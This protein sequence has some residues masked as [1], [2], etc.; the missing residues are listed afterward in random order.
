MYL[1]RY[2]R[3]IAGVFVLTSVALAYFV[4]PLWLI[5]T[6][7]VGLN[8]VIGGAF[9]WCPMISILR[10]IGVRELPAGASDCNCS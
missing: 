5:L 7:F 4:N 2:L 6:A 10:K 9:G 1:D 3:L 8:L